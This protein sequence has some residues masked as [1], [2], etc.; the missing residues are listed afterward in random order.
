MPELPEVETIRRDLE[1][2]IISKRI[3]SVEVSGKRSVRRHK[4][5][6]EFTERLEG[7]KVMSVRRCGK[8]LLIG[9]DQDQDVLDG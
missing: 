5:A 7:R 6:E 8:Y 3:K 4:D 2:E 1:K 9:L